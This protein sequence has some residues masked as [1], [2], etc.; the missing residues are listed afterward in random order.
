[1]FFSFVYNPNTINLVAVFV[2]G[3][4]ITHSTIEPVLPSRATLNVVL[5]LPFLSPRVGGFAIR[6]CPV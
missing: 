5:I 3:M 4:T 1:M 6:L 2:D